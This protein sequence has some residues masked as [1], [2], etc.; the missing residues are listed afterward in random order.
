[1]CA[2]MIVWYK[3]CAQN[4]TT[5]TL[6]TDWLCCMVFVAQPKRARDRFEGYEVWYEWIKESCDVQWF[7]VTIDLSVTMESASGCPAR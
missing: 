1:M 2:E 5:R 3:I 4:C 7:V 6:V